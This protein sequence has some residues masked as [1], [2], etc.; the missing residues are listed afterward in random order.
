[1]STL[2]PELLAKKRK[3]DEQAVAEKAASLVESR[4]KAKAARKDIFKRA[5]SYVEEYRS[6]EKDLVRLKRDAK[7]KGSIY[8]PAEDKLVFVVRIRGLNHVAP[9]VKKILQLL[10]LLQINNGV[11]IR[12][13]K[14]TQGL[15]KRVEPYVAYGYPN[16]KTVKELIYKRGYAKINKCRIP[17]TD[18]RLIEEHLGKFGLICMEDIVHELFTVGPNFK[19]V[20]GFLWPFKLNSASG[21]MDIKRKHYVEG[22]QAGNR[23]DKINTLIRNMN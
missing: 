1:M 16:L 12:V 10:R 2:V 11:F 9:K 13:N 21:G 19:N 23:E 8:V 15:L 22:G 14:A 20:T 5:E 7:A 3:R 18:N 4:K 17:L 6:Q